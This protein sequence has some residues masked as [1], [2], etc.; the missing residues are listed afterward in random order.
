MRKS[1]WAYILSVIFAAVVAGAGQAIWNLMLRYDGGVSHELNRAPEAFAAADFAAR[2][3]TLE[4][5]RALLANRHDIQL[6]IKPHPTEE[7]G[8]YRE[9]VAECNQSENRVEAGRYAR[10]RALDCF[11]YGGAFAFDAEPYLVVTDSGT[12]K[13]MLDAYTSSRNWP[14]SQPV[15]DGTNYL[16]N[17]VKVVID[18]RPRH[19]RVCTRC[20]RS[21]KVLK[22]A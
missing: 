11:T 20:L 19:A 1:A 17:S 13:W 16:R 9:F 12:L 4:I 5:V 15:D 18:G 14:Y 10:G 3:K 22:A 8:R 2:E 21:G 7:H 6:L